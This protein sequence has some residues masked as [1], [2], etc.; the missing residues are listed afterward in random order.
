MS[1]H[2][3]G[4][5]IAIVAVALLMLGLVL[6]LGYR[7]FVSTFSLVDRDIGTIST[8]EHQ[9]DLYVT[10][11]KALDDA[12]ARL[13]GAPSIESIRLRH[14]R[15]DEVVLNG[16]F[17]RPLRSTDELSPPG[18]REVVDLMRALGFSWV[19]KERSHVAFHGRGSFEHG[20]GLLYVKDPGSLKDLDRSYRCK[21]VEEPWYYFVER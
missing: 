7:L 19:E 18:L 11:K 13:G 4:R 3:S 2:I 12:V 10:H 14:E 6:F 9:K 16:D 15:N 20:Y 21:V 5:S 1:P 8:Y 17:D